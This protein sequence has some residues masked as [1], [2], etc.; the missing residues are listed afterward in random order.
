MMKLETNEKH[1]QFDGD[2]ADIVNTMNAE[3]FV[4]EATK[5]QY[6]RAVAKRVYI[7]T[8]TLIAVDDPRTFLYGLQRAGLVTITFDSYDPY[9]LAC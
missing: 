7:L 6:M 8:R 9:T 1:E 4:A 3:S 5:A 2:P